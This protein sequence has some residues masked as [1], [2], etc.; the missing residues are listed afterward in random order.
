[1]DF[2]DFKIGDKVT[3]KSPG[4][5]QL[6]SVPFGSSDLE[7]KV[8]AILRNEGTVLECKDYEV[9]YGLYDDITLGDG[10]V[11]SWKWLGVV[12]AKQYL[13]EC[14]DGIGWASDGALSAL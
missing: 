6:S 12:P 2:N 7:I 8:S 3:S 9:D 1:M 13:I 11:V 5:L 4:G 10:S 14:K